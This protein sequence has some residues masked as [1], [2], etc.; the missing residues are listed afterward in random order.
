MECISK[1]PD[2]PTLTPRLGRDDPNYAWVEHYL[3]RFYGV[4]LFVQTSGAGNLRFSLVRGF[5]TCK[6]LCVM[7]NVRTSV[8]LLFNQREYFEDW[9]HQIGADRSGLRPARCDPAYTKEDWQRQVSLNCRAYI[10]VRASTPCV[11]NLQLLLQERLIAAQTLQELTRR[12]EVDEQ[13]QARALDHIEIEKAAP[14][15]KRK[16]VRRANG[17]TAKRTKVAG[18]DEEG[19]DSDEDD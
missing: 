17:P 9:A 5:S 13:N 6:T 1:I 15:K 10:T 12:R 16:P 19:L 18:A 4:V 11:E 2:W 8:G 3:T 14:L 7:S